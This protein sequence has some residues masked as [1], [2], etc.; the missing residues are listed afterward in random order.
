MASVTLTESA[1]LA[2]DDLVAGIIENIITV[3][4]MYEVLPFD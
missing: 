1:K 4:R 2:L 3:N